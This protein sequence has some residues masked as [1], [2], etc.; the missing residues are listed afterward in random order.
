MGASRPA[1]RLSPPAGPPPGEA[2]EALARRRNDL[3]PDIVNYAEASI[4]AE[5][6]RQ[7]AIQRA[8]EEALRGELRRSRR[9]AAIV[10]VL[11]LFAV[12]AGLVAWW[13]QG[14]A[15]AAL[16]EAER[17]YQ[18]ALD[19]AT[20][21]LQR[22]VDGY[23]QGAIRSKLMQELIERSQQTVTGLSGETNDVTDA[24]VRLLTV[25]SIANTKIGHAAK[26]RDFA[27]QA[28]ALADGLLAKDRS[29]A[30]WT[31]HW[32][33]AQ[34]QLAE[35]LYWQGDLDAALQHAAWGGRSSGS[36]RQSRRRRP[37]LELLLAHQRVGDD[38]ARRAISTALPGPIG[39]GW[40]FQTQQRSDPELAVEAGRHSH[41]N[42]SV[43]TC[44]CKVVCRLPLSIVSF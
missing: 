23:D 16:R 3:D 21:S 37:A 43:T 5:Q 38:S 1:P 20:G 40:S 34:E 30:L 28:I 41:I 15:T 33:I 24:R 31:K 26:G 18:L 36:P 42:G 8:K 2:E 22:L 44:R 7:A 10:S 14:S 27:E 13:Q 4:A 35:A 39:S 12:A 19:Q 32:A 17:N 9:I 6:E 11:L 29:K 25:L